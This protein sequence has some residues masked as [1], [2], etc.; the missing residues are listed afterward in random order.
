MLQSALDDENFAGGGE[1]ALTFQ[2]EREYFEGYP[3]LYHEW[4]YAIVRALSKGWSVRHLCR[5][6][7]N[8]QRSLRLVN[9]ILDWTN[10]SG[11][12]SL[13]YFD[14]YGIDFPPYEIILVNGK[15][16]I[17]GFAADNYKEIDAGLYLDEAEAVHMIERYVGQMFLNVEPLIKI[18][19]QE[20]YFELNPAKDRKSGNHLL[21]MQ[22][23]SFLTVP[24]PLMEK[25]LRISIPNEEERAIHLKRIAD[26][27][28][29]FHR[30]IKHY[31][32]RHIY[33]MR[34]F[35]A[36]VTNGKYHNNVFYRPTGE[37]VREHLL[38]LLELLNT[39]EKFEIAL[40]D[41]NK[42]KPLSKAQCDIK[43]DHT[44]VISVMPKN[45]WDH[46]VELI[47]ITEG[48][49]VNAFQQHFDDW[50]DRINPVHRDK[51]FVI[52]W[53]KEKLDLL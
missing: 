28:Q 26:T 50:W 24:Y 8:V 17:L 21:S 27:L 7:K 5:L 34:A 45:E 51:A 33:P 49:I 9:Q 38:H 47:S 23:L 15:G 4:Q 2:S 32:M 13:Y 31:K 25:Y 42:Y 10:Y 36:L 43:G 41:E 52:S 35:E 12:Y 6:N 1:I 37:D 44:I 14:K 30:D 19:N 48:T 46:K 29:S 11:A 16:A 3:E 20:E 53:I 18:L 40:V 22:D 39:Y